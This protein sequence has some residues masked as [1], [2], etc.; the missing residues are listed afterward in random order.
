MYVG[1]QHAHAGC[2]GQVQKASIAITVRSPDQLP[3]AGDYR[4]YGGSLAADD[5]SSND[6]ET[7]S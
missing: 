1:H 5:D 6:T 4:M 2:I 7:S 3:E